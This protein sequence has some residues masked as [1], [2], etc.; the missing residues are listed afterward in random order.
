[1]SQYKQLLIKHTAAKTLLATILMLLFTTV[2]AQVYAETIGVGV[3]T[4]RIVLDQPVKPSLSYDL[5][6]IAV[7]NNGDVES[8]Y[9]MTV[10]YNETQP[11]QKPP[12]NWISFSP[13]VFNLSPG[14][15]KQVSIKLHPEYSAKPGDY[16]AYLE[17]RPLK[18]DESGQAS[19]SVAA[20]TKF[21]F[22]VIPANFFM[23]IYYSLLAIWITYKAFIIPAILVLVIVIFTLII[24]KYLKIEVKRKEQKQP[25]KEKN[26]N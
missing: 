22:D 24:K 4:G 19:V 25:P 11:E 3:G 5:P 12:A 16:F 7:F 21:H 14:E 26:N 8:D 18:T 10:Q 2:P 15:S 9:E 23:R 20:A 13:G 1:M 6:S 17:A